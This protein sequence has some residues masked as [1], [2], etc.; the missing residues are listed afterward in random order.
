MYSSTSSVYKIRPTL[1]LLRMA[2]KASTLAS[3]A[4]SSRLVCAAEP[5]L[6]EALT[7]TSNKIVSS[8][9]SVNFFTNGRPAR[10]VTFQ[11]IVRTSSPATYSRTSY[12]KSFEIAA[13]KRYARPP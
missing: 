4:A 13:A 8:R 2:E 7:S 5:K 9:S 11:S 12:K 1:S 6:P 10:A 3:S